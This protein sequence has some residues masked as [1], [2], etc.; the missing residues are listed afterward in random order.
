[1][2]WAQVARPGARGG[3]RAGSA[4]PPMSSILNGRNAW[5]EGA[6]LTQQRKREKEMGPYWKSRVTSGALEPREEDP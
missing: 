5:L 4:S 6:L 1:V 2:G 3:S